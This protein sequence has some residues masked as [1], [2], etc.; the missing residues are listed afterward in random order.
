MRTHELIPPN[1]LGDEAREHD[2]LLE[3]RTERVLGFALML[4]VRLWCLPF[5]LLAWVLTWTAIVVIRTTNALAALLHH[6]ARWLGGA[7]TPSR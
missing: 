3:S 1:A 4:A 7:M 6:P 5:L 2:P